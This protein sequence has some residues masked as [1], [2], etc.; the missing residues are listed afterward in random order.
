MDHSVCA[1][2]S[3][4]P[5]RKP[6]WLKV[7]LP[8]G[9]SFHRISRILADGRLHSV[10]REARCPNIAECFLSG[11]ATF[12]IL[13]NTC[14][15]NCRYCH[16]RC[17]TPS[18]V[19]QEEPA[20]LVVAARRMNL[21][22]VV[23]TAVTRDD[24]S[25]GGAAHF[26]A[27]I[28]NLRK[29]LPGSRIEVL[30]PDFQGHPEAL[31]TVIR[32]GPHVI[33]HNLETVPS[34]FRTLRPRGDY[35]RS[36]EVLHR[37]RRWGTSITKS[38]FMVGFG[39]KMTDI[40]EILNDLAGAGCRRLTVGQYQRPTAAHWPV[41]KYY[42]PDEFAVIGEMARTLGFEHV[43][44]APLARSSYHADQVD[45]I[46]QLRYRDLHNPDR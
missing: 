20:R 9:P 42:H 46:M 40:E 24:L 10:C 17:G 8:H 2:S 43:V 27:C 26:A 15:R 34:L 41:L 3:S 16:V 45:K 28:D 14:T 5:L 21:T 31:Q 4:V 18:A 39:E 37:I 29:E 44:S 19:D 30:I 1:M 33:S 12:L 7:R 6:E 23:I 38:G 13:G 32:A 25:D 22:Y 35:R 11:T 36:L